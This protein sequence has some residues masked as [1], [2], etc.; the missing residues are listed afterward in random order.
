MVR[1]TDGE[2]DACGREAN[3]EPRDKYI[4]SGLRLENAYG[5]NCKAMICPPSE[6]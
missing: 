6:C 1:R 2:A 5:Q 3:V 4:S